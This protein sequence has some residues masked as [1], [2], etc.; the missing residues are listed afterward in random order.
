[1]NGYTGIVLTKLD[2]LGGLDELNICTGYDLDGQIIDYMPTSSHD[3]ARCMPVYERHPGFPALKEQEWI[4]MA[5]LSRSDRKG[6]EVLPRDRPLVCQEDRGAIRDPHR[7][8]RNRA[9]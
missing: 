2:V 8:H 6:F 9:R 7:Q 5:E 4:E 3:L 1:M